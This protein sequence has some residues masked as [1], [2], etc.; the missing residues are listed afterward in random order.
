ML[1]L[2][3]LRIWLLQAFFIP[4]H[5]VVDTTLSR[6]LVD[7]IEYTTMH[8]QTLIVM[9]ASS[10][11]SAYRKGCDY[12]LLFC[13]K[14]GVILE[15]RQPNALFLVK[16]RSDEIANQEDPFLSASSLLFMS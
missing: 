8:C 6:L 14:N 9:I 3:S 2:A 16:S 5:V 13:K 1:L 12:A 11:I 4:D 10:V 7:K 15:T